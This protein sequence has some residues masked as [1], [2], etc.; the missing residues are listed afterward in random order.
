MLC[1]RFGPVNTLFFSLLLNAVTLLVVWPV[2]TT[3]GPLI[4]FV[5]LNGLG[6][7]GFFAATPPVVASLFGSLRMP[8]AIGMIITGWGPGY[9]MVSRSDHVQDGFRRQD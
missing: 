2:S 6:N 7:G 4:V 1:D 3:L 9:L 5:I 8:V